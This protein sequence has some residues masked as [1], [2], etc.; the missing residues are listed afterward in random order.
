MLAITGAAQRPG[1]Q[2][3]SHVSGVAAVRAGFAASSA[4]AAQWFPLGGAGPD[5]PGFGAARARDVTQLPRAVL[6]T[7]GVG[8]REV[9]RLVPATQCTGP[10]RCAVAAPA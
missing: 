3:D 5:G 6:A 8:G 2:P 1:R 7:R 4:A 9:A 10:Q